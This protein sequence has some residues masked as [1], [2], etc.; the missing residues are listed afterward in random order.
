MGPLAL[1]TLYINYMNIKGAGGGTHREVA[2]LRCVTDLVGRITL[3]CKT[4][5]EVACTVNL[6]HVLTGNY[7]CTEHPTAPCAQ[8][9]AQTF[10]LLCCFNQ[11]TACICIVLAF[12]YSKRE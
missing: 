7:K 11:L 1:L 5:R 4:R 9:Q 2:A 6:M 10:S 8:L 12:M 3:F